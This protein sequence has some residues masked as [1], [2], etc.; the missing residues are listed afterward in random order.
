MFHIW[1]GNSQSAP[2]AHSPVWGANQISGVHLECVYI[3]PCCDF[4]KMT[5][6]QMSFPPTYV[7][8]K[9]GQ[10]RTVLF[11]FLPQS[12]TLC[13][14]QRVTRCNMSACVYWPWKPQQAFPTLQKINLAE[15]VLRV[16]C[17]NLS[18]THKQIYN[19]K[20]LVYSFS[21]LSW[22][23]M[24]VSDRSFSFRCGNYVERLLGTDVRN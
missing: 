12:H 10:G 18:H 23:C 15:K 11:L 21:L 13:Q 2:S 24:V 7:P 14:C 4:L 17:I 19:P 3:S 9:T 16:W 6:L 1:H 5:S 20:N 22:C 8:L